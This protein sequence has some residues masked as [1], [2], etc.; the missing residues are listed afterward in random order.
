MT[1]ND[2]YA[3]MS[4]YFNNPENPLPSNDGYNLAVWNIYL[5]KNFSFDILKN[6][7][8]L[9][10]STPAIKAIAL[11]ID[12]EGSTLG[13]EL[14]KFGIWCLLYKDQNYFRQIF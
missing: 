13:N 8:Q 9:I 11:S 14:N 10:P 5:E 7:W 1:V 2:Y 6:Q 12:N 4:T 3:Y